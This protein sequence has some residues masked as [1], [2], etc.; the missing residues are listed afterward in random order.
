MQVEMIVQKLK[1]CDMQVLRL[2][3]E[4]FYKSV[5]QAAFF[6]TSDTCLAEDAVHEVFLKLSSRIDQLEGPSKLEAWLCRMAS[7]TAKDI[8][9]H[10][11]RSGLFAETRSVYSDNQTVSPETVLLANED[12]ITI[13]QYIEHLQPAYKI[14]IYLKYYQDLPVELKIAY[15][16][17]LN[18]LPLPRWQNPGHVLKKSY[19]SKSP[20]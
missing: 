3:Y 15:E 7:N 17:W 6:I 19:K 14:V 16:Q 9:R 13:K 4:L 8:I 11:S 2:V 5:Y 1:N 12:K 20:I 10:R 18:Q